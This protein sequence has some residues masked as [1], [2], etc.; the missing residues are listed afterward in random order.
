MNKHYFSQIQFKP[1]FIRK[2]NCNSKKFKKTIYYLST[3]YIYKYN[4]LRI[5]KI[6]NFVPYFKTV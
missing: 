6:C 4:L 5:E 1:S 3:I 2:Q